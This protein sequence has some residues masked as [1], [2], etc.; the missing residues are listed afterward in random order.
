MA[1]GGDRAPADVA[2]AARLGDAVAEAEE[3][4]LDGPTPDMIAAYLRMYEAW[5]LD[6]VPAEGDGG[7]PGARLRLRELGTPPAQS[8]C[9]ACATL[10]D[11]PRSM[12]A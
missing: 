7:V 2:R 6:E 12:R 4:G 9:S 11:L 8:C 1:G 10:R 5:E 3:I